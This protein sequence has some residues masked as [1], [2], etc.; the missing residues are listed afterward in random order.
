MVR[1]SKIP[2]EGEPALLTVLTDITD[3]K[4]SEY[5]I[6][7]GE[8]RYRTL[9]E[10]LN[11]GFLTA[12][13]NAI[14][15]FSNI[16]FQ[17]M[18]KY[19]ADE[20]VGTTIFSYIARD[21]ISI[22]KQKKFN[23][24]HGI[25]ERYQITFISK[26][27][28]PVYTEVSATP[29]HD[30]E[31]RVNGSFAVI[32]D[33]TERKIAEEKI[34]AY[35]REREEKTRELEVLRDQL[36]CT[37]KNLDR[38]VKERTEQVLKLLKQKDEFIMQ[39]G[40]DL[41]TPLTPIIGLLPDLIQEE[42]RDAN[43]HAL[44]LINQNIRYIKDIASKSLKLAKMSSFDINPE[45]DAVDIRCTVSDL[46]TVHE[47]EFHSTSIT[48]LNEV[49]ED[50]IIAADKILFLELLENIISNGIKYIQQKKGV[51]VF[52]ACIS[53]NYAEIRISDNGIGIRAEELETV[54]EEFYKSDR[55]R[56][57]KSSTGLGLSICRRIVKNH[58]GSIW[59][60]S[61][62]PGTGTSFIIMLPLWK[63]YGRQSGAQDE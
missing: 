48:V 16:R 31:G 44:K 43:Q 50:L 7:K 53:G 12:D 36:F 14:I 47:G 27:G 57:D 11:E 46:I 56:H 42:N 18:L 3:K 35:T 19:S 62:G 54:F 41:R 13:E 21:D 59:A 40:H 22:M 17:Q 5:K 60:E 52:S 39:L 24:L 33:I 58:G 51:M 6:K 20:I 4:N 15:T 10:Q 34:R 38:I 61:Q 63:E 55:S 49:P 2:Y 45:I 25:S 23:R 1:A 30:K 37:N 26:P 32:T 29:S 28:D 9:I 8:K